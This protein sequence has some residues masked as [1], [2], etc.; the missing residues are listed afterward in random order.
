[1]PRASATSSAMTGLS[2]TVTMCKQL[3]SGVDVGFWRRTKGGCQSSFDSVGQQ[4]DIGI[5]PGIL[6]VHRLLQFVSREISPSS[7]L[8]MPTN[9]LNGFVKAQ[10]IV[11]QLSEL[12]HELGCDNN[13]W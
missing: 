9:L 7:M 12:I 13:V 3:L 1:M 4:F 6:G 5:Q 11:R 8:G 10:H 2:R